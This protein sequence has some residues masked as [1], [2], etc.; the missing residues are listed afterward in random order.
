V[1]VGIDVGGTFT[2]AVLWDGM[3]LETVKVPTRHHQEDGV[4]EALDAL[5]ARRA[6]L[7]HGTTVATNAVLERSGARTVLV[8]DAGFEDLIEIG[9]QD[10]PSLYDVEVQRPAPLVPADRRVGVVGR[11]GDGDAAVDVD[12]DEAAARVAALDPEAVAVVMLHSFSDPTREQRMEEALRRRIP[13][14]L[15]SLSSQVIPEVREFERA[16]TTVLDAYLR[17]VVSRY[18]ANL[19]R[20]VEPSEATSIHVMRSSG[21]LLGIDAASRLPVATLLSGPAGGVV[22]AAALGSAFGRASVVSFDMGGTSTDVC[23][24][25]GGRPEIAYER[26]VAG[27]PCRMPS[28]AITTV[29]AGGG[30]VAW[31]DSGGALRVG[32]HSAGADPGPAAYRRGGDAATVTDAD[33]ALGRIDEGTRLGGRVALDVSAA[34][35]ALR[36]VADDAGLTMEQVTLGI[37]E[38]VESH[39]ERAIR[40]VSVEEGVDP[41]VSTLVAFGGAGG[42]HATALARRLDMAGVV[43]PAH[44]GVFSALGLLLSPPRADASRSVAFGTGDLDLIVAEV[45][46]EAQRALAWSATDEEETR[47]IVDLRYLG[48]SHETSIPYAPGE[49]RLALEARFHE[50]HR[51]RNGFARPGDPVEVV[52]VRAEATGTPALRWDELPAPDPSGEPRRGRRSVLTSLGDTEASVWWRP[53]LR[54]GDEVAGPAVIEEPGATTYLES[55]DRAKVTDDGALEV[56]W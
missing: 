32:P 7:L 42:L 29:G 24:V 56:V 31:V 8:T 5:A 54:P 18:L 35:T 21:G 53:A 44:A 22:A 27:L 48:Q 4:A 43:V 9:R 37:V 26:A 51:L 50:A 25:E 28:V 2:D 14:V 45:A 3:R 12:W 49:G 46:A 30:S 55:G 10:R 6:Q 47:V 1:R 15:R 38:V 39:M 13:T 40:T 34:I 23:R 36:R 11:S 52:T 17:P 16:S 41:R 19:E 20:S 33:I